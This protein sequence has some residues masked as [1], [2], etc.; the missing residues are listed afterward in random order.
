M[1]DEEIKSNW[2]DDETMEDIQ[3][4]AQIDAQE[5]ES[6]MF[7]QHLLNL[8]DGCKYSDFKDSFYTSD[9]VR[10]AFIVA[11]SEFRGLEVAFYDANMLHESDNVVA[12][13]L[14][15][16]DDDVHLHRRAKKIASTSKTRTKY[17]KRLAFALAYG[18]AMVA[19]M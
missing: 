17:A 2:L 14:H 16:Q 11:D 12:S 15:Q 7:H 3:V 5:A 19:H 1:S 13:V 18:D 6:T 4:Q 8:M 9:L 10:S